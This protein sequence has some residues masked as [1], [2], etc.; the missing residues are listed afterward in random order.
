MTPEQRAIVCA[1]AAAWIG[2]PWQ[3]SARVKGAGVDCA[4]LLIAVYSSVGLI[5]AF[6]PGAYAVDHMMHSSEPVFERWCRS[7]ASEVGQP[8]PGDVVLWKLGRCFSHAGIVIEWPGRVVHA[9]RPYG[10]VC[11]TPA[12]V[13][14]LDGRPVKFFSFEVN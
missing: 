8:Q 1:E 10:L 12:N 5:D 14:H 6:D 3:H 9:Y 13:A 4:Q 11:E 7:L 2:T